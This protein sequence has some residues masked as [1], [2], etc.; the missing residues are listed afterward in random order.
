MSG[1]GVNNTTSF[2]EVDGERYVL[3]IYE[4]HRDMDKV[5]CEH[6]VLRQLAQAKLSFSTPVPIAT[7]T[8]QLSPTS[9]DLIPASADPTSVAEDQQ[10]S[11]GKRTISRTAEGK[12]A[13]LFRYVE[14]ETPSLSESVQLRKFGEVVGELSNALS[15]IEVDHAPAYRPYY[16]LDQAHPSCSL[17][18]VSEC[19]TDPPLELSSSPY[20][21][22]LRVIGRR[23][24]A[25]THNLADLKDLPHQ[26]IHGDLNASNV[27][28]DQMGS[29]TAVLDFEFVTVDLR[30][31]ELAV[32]LSDLIRPD[33][34]TNEMWHSLEALIAGYS[35]NIM[36]TERE[37]TVMP[38]LLLL[39]RLDVFV[40]F[41]GRYWD[42]IDDIQILQRQ[43]VKAAA[44]AN[45][46]EHN[47]ERLCKL[48]R[49]LQINSGAC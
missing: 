39:R 4:T 12:L 48:I 26:W 22:A 33:S 6:A 11:P 14:G 19:C 24:D 49:A 40:H 3:R 32:C 46:L 5:E 43:I 45:W 29:I 9:E 41:L 8:P 16:E 38:T 20:A 18:A 10:W 42:G 1:H 28:A 37:I 23:V 17:E 47:G 25:L 34:D 44:M 27:L 21:E 36:L 15:H 7:A 2:I 35:R 31:M 13:A 30:A